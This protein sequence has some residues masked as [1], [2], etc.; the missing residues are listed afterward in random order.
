[1]QQRI[2]V[3]VGLVRMSRQFRFSPVRQQW[4]NCNIA[5]PHSIFTTSFRI[6]NLAAA[7]RRNEIT[8][9]QMVRETAVDL[10]NELKSWTECLP[11]SW[12]FDMVDVPESSVHL[13]FGCRHHRYPSLW[14]GEAWNNWRALRL[15]VSQLI[16]RNEIQNNLHD[17]DLIADASSVIYEMSLDI[18]ISVPSFRGTHR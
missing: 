1:M 8:D 3:P 9:P 7:L 5:S 18:C 2:S 13:H 4:R 17:T 12:K 16:L 10:A 14:I 6:I 15:I 11:L